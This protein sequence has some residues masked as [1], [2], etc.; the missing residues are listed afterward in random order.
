M[1]DGSGKEASREHRFHNF[2]LWQ[3]AQGSVEDATLDSEPEREVARLFEGQKIENCHDLHS[4]LRGGAH[5]A[6]PN[7][8]TWTMQEKRQNKMKLDQTVWSLNSGGLDGAWRSLHMLDN[9]AKSSRPAV[10]CLQE[11][12][13]SEEQWI[14]MQHFLRLRGYQGY[15]TGMKNAGDTVKRWHRGVATFV[16]DFLPAIFVDEHTWH[17]GQFHIIQLG[18]WMLANYYVSPDDDHRAVQVASFFERWQALN[19][20]GKWLWL[21]DFNE[22]Y[23]DSWIS[24]ATVLSGGSLVQFAKG[25][26]STRWL[27]NR[28][29][30]MA[31]CNQDLRP[32]RVLEEK[33]SDHKILEINLVMEKHQKEQT[34]FIFDLKFDKPRWLSKAQW[35]ECFDNAVNEGI[36]NQWSEAMAWADAHQDW[37]DND[38]NGQHAVDLSWCVL[39]SQITWSFT[40][41]AFF[42]LLCIPSD[43]T[44]EK[45][46]KRVAIMANRKKPKGMEVKTQKRIMPKLGNSNTEHFRKMYKRLGRLIE[47]E[48][49]MTLGK[50]CKETKAL[51]WKIF[52][53]QLHDVN[54]QQITLSRQKLEEEVRKYEKNSKTVAIEKWRKEMN[55]DF[56]KKTA[57]INK[58]GNTC[59]ATVKTQDH[60]ADNKVDAGA[61]LKQYWTD[62]WK[63]QEWNEDDRSK[64]A[65]EASE[66]LKPL[67]HSYH[68]AQGRPDVRLFALKLGSIAGCAGP[69]GWCKEELSI[70]SENCFLCELIWENM[71]L[72]EFFESIPGA[73]RHCRLSHIPKKKERTLGPHQ[74]R[75]ICV[76]SVWWRA[77]SM[78]WLNSKW[79]KGWAEHMFPPTVAGGT[80]GAFGPEKMAAIAAH[81]LSKYHNG[82]SLDFRHAFDTVD[83]MLLDKILEQTLPIQCRTWSKLIVQQWCTMSRWI[84]YEGVA[85]PIPLTS[86]QGLPQGDPAAALMMT[87]LNF[88]LKM[89]VERELGH[90]TEVFH[91]IYMDDRTIIAKDKTVLEAMKEQWKITAENF[92]LI[93]NTEKAKMI[94]DIKKGSCLEVLGSLLGSPTV[95][96]LEKSRMGDR[97]KKAEKLYKKV[98]ILPTNLNNKLKD[99]STYGR[100]LL[101]YGWIDA[102]PPATW[103]RRQQAA[104]WKSAAR[105]GFANPH[106]KNTIGGAHSNLKMV[107]LK[108]QLRLIA[109]RNKALENVGI[110]PTKCKMD[111]FVES[112]LHQLGW[113]LERGRYR[114]PSFREGFRICELLDNE[115]WKCIGHHLRESYRQSEFDLY[116]NCNRHEVSNYHYGAYDSDRRQLAVKWA[117]EDPMALMLLIGGIQSPM[118]KANV[119]GIHMRCS[120]CNYQDPDWTHLWKCFTNTEPPCD[121][122]LARHIWPRNVDDFPLCQ[123]FLDGIRSL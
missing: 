26:E 106:M 121:G 72:W 54:L 1:D 92:H 122:L 76:M 31:L 62:L 116:K 108:K 112:T 38:M 110:Q 101:D 8:H 111:N 70:I 98:G 93:E 17:G 33:I 100:G 4:Q 56:K 47:L 66:L 75:P 28:L 46:M 94:N 35:Q 52:Q 73:V 59:N 103:I 53:V 58:K 20:A 60:I 42:A 97:L 86:Q 61:M 14:G 105:T 32:I 84:C 82:L 34:R 99:N 24:T 19:W 68:P 23:D 80:P 107:A 95:E 88:A 57:W 5:N 43:F 48:K 3:A 119:R 115:W 55:T 91:T 123:S 25:I 85:D 49:K 83:L 90:P 7:I 18:Q 12:G 2:P 71:Q 30:D 13:C 104:Y 109:E 96:D 40:T 51:A 118:L 64:R 67:L 69:D 113:S 77:W 74:F 9:T 65:E 89:I 15:C 102:K 63:Q 39:L 36:T 81:Q 16:A 117:A 10:L 27:G 78:S 120:K 79:V 41:A 45:E 114:H 21:G 29:I 37:P 50:N 11:V 44:D 6:L 87:T 22:T